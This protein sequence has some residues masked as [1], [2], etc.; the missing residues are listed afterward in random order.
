MGIDAGSTQAHRLISYALA[1]VSLISC[2]AGEWHGF[3][4]PDKSMLATSIDIGSY[5]S[6]DGCRASARN[7]MQVIS[8]IRTQ[9]RITLA[10]ALGELP[11]PD[12]ECGL[13]C[14]RE[15]GLTSMLCDE[16]VR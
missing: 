12:Y 3:V 15:D 9:G 13:N 16:T 4:Y 8:K 2:S 5:S 7:A 11:E 10:E 6:L 1:S 14:R